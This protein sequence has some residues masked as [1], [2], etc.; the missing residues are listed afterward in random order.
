MLKNSNSNIIF[1]KSQ[2]HVKDE[3]EEVEVQVKVENRNWG[4]GYKI[5]RWQNGNFFEVEKEESE[6]GSFEED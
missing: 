4:E 5:V 1:I 6:N 3:I 2:E